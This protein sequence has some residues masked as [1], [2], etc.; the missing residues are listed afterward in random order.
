MIVKMMGFLD[1]LAAA[2]I[3]L[4]HYD[5]A[6]WKLAL[7]L[8]IYLIGKGYALKGSIASIL[9]VVAG[10]YLIFSIFSSHWLLSYVFA[11]FLAQKGIS[12]LIS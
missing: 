9:D 12:S 8:A 5:V 3:L 4:L 10:F 6:G 11:L 2:S 7:G 1:L